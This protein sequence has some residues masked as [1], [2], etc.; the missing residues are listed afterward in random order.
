L[1]SVANSLRRPAD[2]PA[3]WKVVNYV[4]SHDEVFLGRSP[5]IAALGDASNARSWYARSRARVANGLVLTSPG[6]PM[7]FMGQEFLEDKQWSD[8][9]AGGNLIWWEGLKTNR[10]MQ[11]HLR[12]TQELVWLRRRHPALRA[13]GFQVIHVHNANRVIAFQRWIPEIGRTV[14]VVASLNESSFYNYELGFPAG[15]HWLEVFNS[16][17]Y[18]H[19]VN[20]AAAGNGGAINASGAPRDSMPSSAAITIPANGL[21]VFARD[22]GD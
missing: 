10:A 19:W 17:V 15:G 22:S 8:Y 5:R 18:D 14:L 9:P 4:E 1:D 21:I 20:P 2:F 7:L 13:Q 11:D 3:I 12:F 6:I 16:D